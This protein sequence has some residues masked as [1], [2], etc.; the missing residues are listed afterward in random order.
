MKSPLASCIYEGTV[1]HRRVSPKAH[2]FSYPVYELYLDLDELPRIEEET[3]LFRHN[4]RGP[5]AFKDRDYMGPG[6]RPIK[7]KL[8]T[9]W[10]RGGSCWARGGSSS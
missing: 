2:E 1:R 10:R 9:G 5:I 4:G 7:E 8:R 6:E 3:G